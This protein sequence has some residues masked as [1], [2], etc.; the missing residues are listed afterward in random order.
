MDV[1]SDLFSAQPAEKAARPPSLMSVGNMIVLFSETLICYPFGAAAFSYLREIS[2]KE[3]NVMG[4][5]SA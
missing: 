3:T 1:Q 2:D 5:G 4:H